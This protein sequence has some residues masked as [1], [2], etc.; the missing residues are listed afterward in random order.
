MKVVYCFL[1]IFPFISVITAS[2]ETDADNQKLE[3]FTTDLQKIQEYCLE[4]ENVTKTENLED[5]TDDKSYEWRCF[6]GCVLSEIG[7]V[8]RIVKCINN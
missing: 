3:Q 1:V 5:E 7:L 2:Y 4:K 6:C 8:S